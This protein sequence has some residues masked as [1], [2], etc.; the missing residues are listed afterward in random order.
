MN[1]KKVAFYSLLVVGVGLCVGG[2]FVPVLLPVGSACIAGAIAVAQGQDR[3]VLPQPLPSDNRSDMPES[4]S[5]PLSDKSDSN[6]EVDLHIAHHRHH[7]SV[8]G[9]HPAQKDDSNNLE[10]KENA[11][12]QKNPVVIHKRRP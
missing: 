12:S 4:E 3:Q 10:S 11:D 2:I 5:K 8:A 1:L 6:L 9:K 7:A